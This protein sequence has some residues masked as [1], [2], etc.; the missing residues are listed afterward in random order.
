MTRRTSIMSDTD[1][2]GG[3]SPRPTPGAPTAAARR[4]AA[5]LEAVGQDP[6]AA[7]Y[8]AEQ[9]VAAVLEAWPANAPPDDDE[10]YREA[11]AALD[12]LE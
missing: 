2:D 3:P 9:T 6:E 5:D 4:L 11:R 1:P 8:I 12:S 10:V 7:A